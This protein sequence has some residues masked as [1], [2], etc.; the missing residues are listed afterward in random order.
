MITIKFEGLQNSVRYTS[1]FYVNRDC[2][3]RQ[4]KIEHSEKRCHVK[5]SNKAPSDVNTN[6]DDSTFKNLTSSMATFETNAATY[7]LM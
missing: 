7:V 5:V 4:L 1:V 2:I 6:L 3:G